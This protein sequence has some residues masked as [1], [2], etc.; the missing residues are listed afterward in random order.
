VC[1][2]DWLCDKVQLV[3]W[4]FKDYLWFKLHK[5]CFN[6]ENDCYFC[7]F[8][9]APDNSP[10]YKNVNSELFE[11]DLQILNDAIVTYSTQGDVW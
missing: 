10:V 6:F 2:K 3:K 11:C 7:V 1:Y 9:I 5:E 8:Y 4:D